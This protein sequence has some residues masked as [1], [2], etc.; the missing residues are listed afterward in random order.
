[1]TSKQYC[2]LENNKCKQHYNHWCYGNLCNVAIED[3]K[4][5]DDKYHNNKKKG[6]I[7]LP[8]R[9]QLNLTKYNI[10]SDLYQELFYFCKRYNDRRE[11]IESLYNLSSINTDGMPK[12][13]SISNQTESKAI[14]INKLRRENE[15]IEQAAVE[16]DPHIYQYIIKNVTEGTSYEYLRAPC[17]RKQ[18]Y[19]KRRIFF[20]ILS[21]KR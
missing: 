21:E 17:G 10:N 8:N 18:F 14:R 20:K 19:E 16:A 6:A 7:N 4:L 15:L 1:M 13:N 12:G 9:R 3:N 5:S 2:P 11:E